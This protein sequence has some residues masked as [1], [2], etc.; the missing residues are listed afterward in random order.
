MES[1]FDSIVSDRPQV[2]VIGCGAVGS[3]VAHHLAAHEAIGDVLLADVD[4]E[5]AKR[6][7]AH[8]RSPKARAMQIDASDED[9]LRRAMRGCGL[10]INTALPRFNRLIQSAALGEHVNYLDP[11]ND[12]MSSSWRSR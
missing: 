7:A 2:L 9:A 1:R 6:T 10:V 3:V 12:T 4:G 11:A 8:L 5:L